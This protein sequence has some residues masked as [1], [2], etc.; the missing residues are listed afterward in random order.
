MAGICAKLRPNLEIRFESSEPE[1]PVIVKDPITRGFYRFSVVQAAVLSR[2][3]GTE[4]PGAIAQAVSRECGTPVQASQV[5]EFARNLQ[6]LLLLD[7]PTVWAK[8][9]SQHRSRNRFFGNL[10]SIKIH[11]F[12]PDPLLE[13]LAKRL[14]FLFSPV[15]NVL[16]WTAILSASVI[17]IVNKEALLLS[18]SSLFS[19]YSLPL[20][21]AVAF[22]VMTIH[23]F[24]H[25]LTLKHFGGKVQE[26]GFLVLYFIPAFYSNVD[27][28]WLL[29]RKQRVLVTTAGAY[30][31]LFVAALATIAWRFLAVETPASR[32]LVVVIAFSAVQM[33]FNLIPLIRLDGYYLLSDLLQ[34]PNLRPRAFTY[35][36]QLLGRWLLGRIP[37]DD[38]NQRSGREKRIYVLYGFASFLFTAGILWLALERLGGWML[39]KY[40]M[41]GLLVVAALC[42]M[43]LSTLRLEKSKAAAPG[44][45]ARPARF[46]AAWR[47]LLMGAILAGIGVLPWELKVAGDFMIVPNQKIY[48]TPE[49]EGIL[50]TINVNEG[51]NV[52]KGDVL[53]Q[54]ENLDLSNS[55]EETRGELESRR[56]SLDLLNA[57]NRPEEIERARRLVATKRAELASARKVDQERAVLLDTVA[58]REAELNNA[59]KNYERMKRL[60]DQ[61]L[62]A[63]ADLERDQTAFEVQQK[64]L[65]E[66]RGQL[67]VLAER[68][69][70]EVQVRQKE[71][72]Q[73]E[74]ELSILLAGSR[75]ESIRAVEAEVQKLQ[76]KLSILSR[77]L[78]QLR[79]RS[80]LDGIIATPYLNNRIGEY[81]QKGDTFCEIVSSGMVIVDL[82][83]PE[84]EI[85][86]VR[87]GYPITLKVRGY[88]HRTFEARVRSISPVAVEKDAERKV[89]VQGELDNSDG[90]LKAGMSGVGKILCGKRMIA[91]L[92]TRRAVRWL[93]TEFW[94]YLP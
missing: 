58:K 67:S 44:T 43:S 83:V 50:K 59:A 39:Q 57:G 54:I 60:Y 12:N 17:A 20:I 90:T 66:A 77:Q 52:R 24:A 31:Q 14:G 6:K 19:L 80:P 36:K 49:V 68:T 22:V 3:N 63:R 4:E 45:A 64:E 78:E 81:L 79:I 21:L 15:F 92:A 9:E 7:H 69:D 73:A 26:M 32:I 34:I 76:E 93:R 29:P 74:S 25:A 16:M 61:G 18:M 23:E 82:P 40:R 10:L 53:A 88:P 48:I 35:L 94:E 47:L 75:K 1:S 30:A 91:D 71:L 86:D 33:F 65:L 55:F 42:L 2:L 56:A 84:K 85:A 37:P 89:V 38:A 46:G 70:R 28:A 8:L 27:D 5:E 41:W 62:I 87:I 11:A 51:Q 72:E 13:R